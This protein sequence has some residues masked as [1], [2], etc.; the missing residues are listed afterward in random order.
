MSDLHPL[1]RE[2]YSARAFLD[3]PVEPDKL[4]R[5][6]EAARQAPSCFN[7]QPWTFLIAIRDRNSSMWE[8][9]LALLVPKNQ[10]WARSAPVLGF[11]IARGHFHRNQKPNRWSAYD[12]GQSIAHLTVQ[13]QAESLNVHQ[14][15]GFDADAARQTLGIPEDHQPMAAFAIGYADATVE[16][17]PSSRKP[18]A[19]VV[20]EGHW[21]QSLFP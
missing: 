17:T 12:T 5:I 16:R 21:N 19:E 6:F 8:Q 2:R 3:R 13:A 14:M 4:H 11:S 15:G 18:L 10:E 9:F 7:D 1:L 20:F